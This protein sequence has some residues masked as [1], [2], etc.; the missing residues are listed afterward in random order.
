MATAQRLAQE[1]ANVV[2]LD[3]PGMGRELDA[4]CREFGATSLH[5]DIASVD[6]PYQVASFLEQRFGGVDIVVHNAGV[7]RDRTLA[8]MSEQ[9]WDEVIAINLAAIFAL[10]E[11]LIGKNILRD[12]GRV[13]CLSS[14]SGVAGNFGQ[15][16]YATTKAA[17][18]GYVKA[19]A[20]A[21]AERNISING[22]APGFIETPMTAA[23]PFATREIGRRLNSLKQS[24]LPR[25]VAELIT[26]LSSPQAFG[27]TGNT[28][29][30]CG[31]GLIGA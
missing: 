21:L 18:I 28:I 16:N 10:D 6:A 5:V 3:I 22:V 11:V 17:V 23:M 19:R 14:I 15:S 20:D 4:R 26:F 31:Q 7:T 8:N 2:C 9:Q 29:R 1:G 13:V 24:G 25:D 12:E 30:V 27:L